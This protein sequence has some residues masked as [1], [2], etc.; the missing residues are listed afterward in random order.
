MEE[1][2]WKDSDEIWEVRETL[3]NITSRF[4]KIFKIHQSQSVRIYVLLFQFIDEA[5]NSA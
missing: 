2:E 4:I 5:H 1:P 3:Q